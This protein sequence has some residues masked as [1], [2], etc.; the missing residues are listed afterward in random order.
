ME[1]NQQYHRASLA[2]QVHR[3]SQ[4]YEVAQLNLKIS[5]KTEQKLPAG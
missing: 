5:T 1:N 2:Q 4:W 3:S